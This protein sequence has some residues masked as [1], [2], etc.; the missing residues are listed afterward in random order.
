MTS[1]K[2]PGRTW[3]WKWPGAFWKAILHE[4]MVERLDTQLLSELSIAIAIL[5][6][7]ILREQIPSFSHVRSVARYLSDL[8]ASRTFKIHWLSEAITSRVERWPWGR[9]RLPLKIKSLSKSCR[10]PSPQIHSFFPLPPQKLIG[11]FSLYIKKSCSSSCILS[12]HFWD[13]TIFLAGKAIFEFHQL[14]S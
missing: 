2:A 5:D 10:L 6:V 13:R 1:I 8:S 7:E 3:G 14:L 9:T 11:K 4:T 12:N